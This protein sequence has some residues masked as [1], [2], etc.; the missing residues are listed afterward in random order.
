MRLSYTVGDRL[1]GAV[2]AVKEIQQLR[3]ETLFL[4][5]AAEVQ[6]VKPEVTDCR[7]RAEEEVVEVEI[8]AVLEIEYISPDGSARHRRHPCSFG[9]TALMPE[10]R[11]GDL[12]R[13]SAEPYVIKQ[14]FSGGTLT[15]SLVFHLVLVLLREEYLPSFALSR[16]EFILA[17]RKFVNRTTTLLTE[18]G[19]LP[20]LMEPIEDLSVF[21]Y[22][23]HNQ[24]TL[25][26]AIARLELSPDGSL[27]VPEPVE[28]VVPPGGTVLMVPQ[29]FLRFVRVQCR[30]GRPGRPARLVLWF[31][32]QV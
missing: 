3:E 5:E 24:S 6:G 11:P 21:S 17:G 20:S 26:E 8:E 15:V 27:W 16:G 25:N 13:V 2:T 18:D 32:G 7:G 29:H 31:Q 10:S 14:R 28:K 9:L 23:L 30:S 19:F 12:V 22:C 4:A 1:V